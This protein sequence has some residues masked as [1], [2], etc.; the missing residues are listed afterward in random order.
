[1]STSAKAEIR[2]KISE[3]NKLESKA[4]KPF[5]KIV[6]HVAPPAWMQAADDEPVEVTVFGRAVDLF[7]DLR[8]G[9][10]A[11]AICRVQGRA[12]QDRYY[13]S[14]IGEDLRDVEGAAQPPAQP[15][16]DWPQ[17]QPQGGDD[18]VPF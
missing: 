15:A 9:H 10:T 18:D 2:G 4:G 5:L 11:T 17:S 3:V 12:W 8:P 13:V 6:F 16:Q 7:S 1:M 14:L